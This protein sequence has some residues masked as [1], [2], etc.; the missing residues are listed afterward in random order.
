MHLL[1]V[2]IAPGYEYFSERKKNKT[3]SAYYPPLGLLYI[4]SAAEKQDHSVEIIDFHA[5]KQPFE[6]L[7]RSLPST[8]IVGVSVYTQSRKDSVLITDYIKEVDSTLPVLIGGPHCSLHPKQSL[9]DIPSANISVQGEAERAINEILR[10]IQGQGHLSNIAGVHYRDKGEIKPGRPQSIICDLDSLA[11]PSRILVNKYDYGKINNSYFFKPRFTSMISSRGCSFRCRFCTRNTLSFQTY[12]RRSIENFI[13]EIKL[14]NESYGSVIIVDDNFMTDKQWV[15]TVMD[16]L[17]NM[18]IELEIYIQG[19]RVDT[20]NRELLKKMK[21][22]GIKHLYFGIESGNQDVLNYYRKK[23]TLDQIKKTIEL[24]HE[25]GFYTL[26]SFILGAP[27]ETQ[28]HIKQTIKFAC[29]LPLDAAVFNILT[30]KYGSD[31]WDEAV[32][33]GKIKKS[34]GYTIMADS[35][36]GLGNFTLEELGNFY[37]SAIIQFNLRPRYLLRHLIRSIRS[38]DIATLKSGFNYFSNILSI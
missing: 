21:Q 15:S 28:K 12:R 8:D 35:E 4:S 25:L 34:D 3:R 10:V 37:R 13:Q 30:Y 36:K 14:I 9:V 24:S 29:S 23:T 27:I 5:E 17:I 26:G 7:K 6:S 18:E 32:E 1:L 16:R 20:A 2:H 31:L 22:A 33:Q 11:F 19:A 38:H